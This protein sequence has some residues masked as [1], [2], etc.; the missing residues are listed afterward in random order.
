MGK[1]NTILSPAIATI[2]HIDIEIAT[3]I[4][5]EL[6]LI[7]PDYFTYSIPSNDYLKRY[8]KY[9]KESDFVFVAGTN[10]ISSR[11]HFP[12]TKQWKLRLRDALFIAELIL[13]G[14]GWRS[15]EGDPD[16]YTRFLLK[17]V[18]SKRFMHSVRDSYTES[19]LRAIGINNVINTGCPTMWS[20]SDEFVSDIPTVKA[21][22]AVITLCKGKYTDERIDKRMVEIVKDNYDK[23]FFWQ[24]A[25]PDLDYLQTL[26]SDCSWKNR[27]TI[28]SCNLEAYMNILA[29]D[30]SLDSIGSRLHG[31]IMA[32]NHKR[33]T[34]IVGVDN[35]ALE[36]SKDTGLNVIPHAQVA[37]RL[38][39]AIYSDAPPKIK[40]P[41]DNIERWKAQFCAM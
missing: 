26:I 34:I 22:H 11:M 40:I 4:A 35:R 16:T 37:H 19:K 29:S 5:H 12:Y 38:E 2:N 13:I 32:L 15:Y 31:G 3:R 8:R 1:V 21:D 41:F 28:I 24:Q 10:L 9:T 18:L 25:K 23:V 33:R 7:F 39:Q 6:N 17:R 36:I 27:I 20:L 14:V 30:L